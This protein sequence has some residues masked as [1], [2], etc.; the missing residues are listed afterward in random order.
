MMPKRKAKMDLLTVRQFSS[1]TP[2]PMKQ[3]RR[4]F[5]G[6]PSPFK[7]RRWIK[8]GIIH[9]ETGE[10]IRLQ[11]FKQ[12]GELWTTLESYERFLGRLN[13]G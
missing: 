11:C 13:G 2:V 9:C 1:E 8:Y 4:L 3:V 7:V 5:L 12:A 10:T 6:E